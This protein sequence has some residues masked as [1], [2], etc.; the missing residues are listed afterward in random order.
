M[1]TEL[2]FPLSP[3]YGF[4]FVDEA[5]DISP[6]EYAVLRAVNDRA[7]FNVFGDLKQNITG[8][9]GI[10]DWGELGYKVYNLNLN[11][12]N[13]NNIVDYVSEK[14]GIEMQAIGFEGSGVE[15]I[16]ARSVTRRLSEKNGLWRGDLR[17]GGA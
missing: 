3:K 4:V 17:R 13:T 11:Y 1:L 7:S 10:K 16:D 6:A 5:Q 15:I 14:L 2:G 9:R 12:R 8:Y